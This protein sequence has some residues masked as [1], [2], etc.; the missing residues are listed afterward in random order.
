MT[1][2]RAL[3]S[4]ILIL[5]LFGAGGCEQETSILSRL[6]VQ[7]QTAADMGYGIQ[8]TSN[9]AVPRGSRLIYAELLGD[10]LV[11]FETGNIL[12]CIRADTGQIL[13]REKVGSDIERFSKPV[14]DDKRVVISSEIHAY[15]YDIEGGDLLKVFPLA[16]VSN[17]TPVVVGGLLIFGSPTGVVFAQDVS[18]GLLRWTYQV[19]SAVSTNPVIAGPTLITTDSLGAVVAFNPFTGV[20]LWRTKAW[21]R[22]SA[23]PA[24]SDLMVYVASEDQSLYALE[25]TSG[26]QRWRYYARDPLITPP[27][28]VGDYLLT[29]VPSEGLVCL[30]SITGDKLFTKDMPHARPLGIHNDL[31]YIMNPGRVDLLDPVK[32]DIVRSVPVPAVQHIVAS[33]PRDGDLYLIRLNGVIMKLTPR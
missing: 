28:L 4:V 32:G 27:T 10:K 11:T 8:W 6:L 16:Y 13:W 18:Q 24:A 14:R 22:V 7:P 17:T 2:C 23:E 33:A 9:L 15:V 3:A 5:A 29:Y 30:D 12:S 19:G 25:R 20:V 31:L 26:T 1:R 21:G